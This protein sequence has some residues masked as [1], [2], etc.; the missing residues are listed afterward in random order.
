MDCIDCPL[1]SQCKKSNHNRGIEVNPV[2]LQLQDIAKQ[3]L[4]SERGIQL[5]MNRSAQSEST[6][7]ILKYNWGKQRFTRRGKENVDNELHLLCI[8][9]NLMKYHQRKLRKQL[10]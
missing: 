1:T 6:F 4:D 9:Y 2:L 10:T 7:G 5:R 3:N 8:G